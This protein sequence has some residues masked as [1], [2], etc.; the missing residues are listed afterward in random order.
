MY[1]YLISQ[2][3]VEGAI[4]RVDSTV[5]SLEEDHSGMCGVW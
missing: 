5:S 2:D 4:F 3:I 1:V